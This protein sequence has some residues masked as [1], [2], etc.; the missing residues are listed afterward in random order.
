MGTAI[1]MLFVWAISLIILILVIAQG[2][3][4]GMRWSRKDERH[5]R[6]TA[7]IPYR[8]GESMFDYRPQN[9]PQFKPHRTDRRFK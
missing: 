5:E 1:G 9:P 3:R 8:P 7:G 2:V 6:E 4:V